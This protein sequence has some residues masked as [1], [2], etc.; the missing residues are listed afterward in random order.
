M[1]SVLSQYTWLQLP[2][3]LWSSDFCLQFYEESD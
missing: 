3:N 2:P 1:S